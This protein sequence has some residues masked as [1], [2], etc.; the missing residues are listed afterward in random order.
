MKESK[1]KE[2]EGVKRKR[3]E[4][5]GTR[6]TNERGRRRRAMERGGRKEGEEIDGTRS[7]K[8]KEFGGERWNEAG[9]ARGRAYNSGLF[10]KRDLSK[11][12]FLMTGTDIL[13]HLRIVMAPTYCCHPICDEETRARAQENLSH[14]VPE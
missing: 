3:E 5:H 14:Y 13:W 8:E 9:N 11:W 1:W 6:M 2:K 12:G 7:K 10:C 4:I